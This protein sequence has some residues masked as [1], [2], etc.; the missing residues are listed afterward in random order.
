MKIA[1]IY[2]RVSSARQQQNETIGSQ[3]EALLSYAQAHDYQVS[4]QHIYQD[5]GYSGAYLDR[6]ALERLRDAVAA[7]ELEAV[8]LVSPDRLPRRFAY[9]FIV[10]EEFQRACC[11][12]VFLNH[13][14]TFAVD[15]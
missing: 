8:L 9:Q 4:P 7:G 2:A 3:L 5:D 15:L 6:P 14:S 12:V 11:R 1:A 13:H 10:T